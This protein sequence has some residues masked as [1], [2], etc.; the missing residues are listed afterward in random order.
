MPRIREWL[1]NL[2]GLGAKKNALPIG[3]AKELEAK[4][5][6]LPAVEVGNHVLWINPAFRELPFKL[7]EGKPTRLGVFLTS[8][9]SEGEKTYPIESGSMHG[10]SGIVGRAIFKDQDGQ[11]YRDIDAKGLGSVGAA[12]LKVSSVMLRNEKESSGIL[13]LAAAYHDKE[14][15][16]AFHAAGIGAHRVIAIIS[17]EEIVDENGKKISIEEARARGLIA[18]SNKPVIEIRSFGTRARFTDAGETKNGRL[19]LDDAKALVAQE[20]GCKPENFSDQDYLKWLVAVIGKNLGLM[21]KNFWYHGYLNNE[22]NVTLDGRFVDFDS[23]VKLNPDH[24]KYKDRERLFQ[25]DNVGLYWS[26]IHLVRGLTHR[27]EIDSSFQEIFGQEYKK[28]KGADNQAK[29]AWA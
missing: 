2:G 26:F 14:T 16:E 21:H 15:S 20:L 22:H 11:F 4:K 18:K 28:A 23:V 1:E 6:I 19:Y 3:K 5:E 27:H 8:E 29:S 10:R 9:P 17:L 13:D 12:E 24:E 25:E 7:E